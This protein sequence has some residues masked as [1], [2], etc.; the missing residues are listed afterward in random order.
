MECYALGIWKTPLY[1]CIESIKDDRVA[2][3]EI[4][5]VQM[6]FKKGGSLYEV[7]N[8]NLILDK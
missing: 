4:P 7:M 8:E 6:G 2:F 3:R 1:G 5:L